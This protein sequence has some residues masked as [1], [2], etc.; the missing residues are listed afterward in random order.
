M[1]ARERRGGY[2]SA[3]LYV[4]GACGDAGP[5]HA[6]GM[7]VAP[8]RGRPAAAHVCEPADATT[9]PGLKCNGRGVTR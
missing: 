1:A 3:R 4:V 9:M 6:A 7:A 5:V 8:V 2:A